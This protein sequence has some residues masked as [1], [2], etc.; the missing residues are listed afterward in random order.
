MLDGKDQ[1]DRKCSLVIADEFLRALASESLQ[2]VGCAPQ[3]P[4]VLRIWRQPEIEESSA[5]AGPTR[6]LTMSTPRDHPT[7]QRRTKL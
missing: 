1:P 4:N 3:T 2:L 6:P 7:H 5:R